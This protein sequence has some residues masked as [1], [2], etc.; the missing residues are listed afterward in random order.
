MDGWVGSRVAGW[1]AVCLM[2]GL[3]DRVDR[4]MD[5]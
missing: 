4:W 5:G 3:M 1:V 2:D